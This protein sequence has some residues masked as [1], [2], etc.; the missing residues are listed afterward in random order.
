M[1]SDSAYNYFCTNRDCTECEVVTLNCDPQTY[2][3]IV[4]CANTFFF[5]IYNTVKCG[6]I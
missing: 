6:V 4:I 3:T 1:V 2:L 5:Y